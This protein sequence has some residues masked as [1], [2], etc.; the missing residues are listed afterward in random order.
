MATRWLLALL[1]LPLALTLNACSAYEDLDPDCVKSARDTYSEMR[2]KGYGGLNS[3]SDWV[4]S[5]CED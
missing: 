3:E 1:A 5:I 2:S 4:Y